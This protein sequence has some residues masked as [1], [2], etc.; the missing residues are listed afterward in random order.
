MLDYNMTY[1]STAQV[2][3]PGYCGQRPKEKG[4]EDPWGADHV[5]LKPQVTLLK[6]SIK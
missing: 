5:Y 6:L 4:Q 1:F 2:L 3:H